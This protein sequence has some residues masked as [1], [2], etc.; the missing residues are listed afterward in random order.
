MASVED[1]IRDVRRLSLRP[2]DILVVR[3]DIPIE[4]DQVE[5]LREFVR[6]LAGPDVGVLVLDAK[7]DLEVLSP[8]RET[9][10]G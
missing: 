1:S 4:H 10:I 3:S 7:S 2:G 9:R 6:K 5:H 8:E